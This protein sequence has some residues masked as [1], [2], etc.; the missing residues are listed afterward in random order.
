MPRYLPDTTLAQGA[1]ETHDPTGAIIPPIHLATTFLRP[2]EGYSQTG[3]SYSRYGYPGLE[4]PEATLR[5]LEGAAD[6]RLFSSGMSAMTAVIM[7]LKPGSHCVFPIDMYHGMRTWLKRYSAQQNLKFSHADMT[8]LECMRAAII[9]GQTSIVWA[10][11]PSNPHWYLYDIAAL[12]DIAH[13]AGAR[14]VVDNT[15]AT[16]VL[17]QPLSF[18]ADIV[19]HSATKYLNGHSDVLAGAAMTARTDD[20][21]EQVCFNRDYHGSV[22]GQ[23]QAAL[24][25]RGMRT[26]HLRVG[27]A[28]ASAMTLAT[29]C[30]EHP[31]VEKV[32][33]PG[34]PSHPGHDL[35]KRQMTGGFGGM[36]SILVKGGAS[37]ADRV[38]ARTRVWK[39]ATSLGGVESLIER[40]EAIEPNSHVEPNL[41]RLSVGIEAASDLIDDLWTALG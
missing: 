22:L 37:E 33:Y 17:S 12:A 20:F 2:S 15:V 30:L 23:F 38:T 3:W 39:P 7:A 25:M 18:G 5:T 28:C 29:A 11:T 21:W 4:Q 1:C 14:L 19:V 9:P 8:D 32:Y 27:R 6:C 10:E 34:L 41:L 40:R 35:A 31:K 26:L 24:L 13:K 36:V 16:P